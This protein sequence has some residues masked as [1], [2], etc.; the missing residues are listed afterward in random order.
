MQQTKLSK[1]TSVK[2]ED[3][4]KTKMTEQEIYN[5]LKDEKFSGK[6]IRLDGKAITA[7]QVKTINDDKTK[8]IEEETYDPR[9]NRIANGIVKIILLLFINIIKLLINY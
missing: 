3:E 2:L 8:K 4:K 7:N 6:P 1:T 5:K 9:K